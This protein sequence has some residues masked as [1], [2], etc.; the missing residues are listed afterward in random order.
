MVNMTK[1]VRWYNA[2]WESIYRIKP[3]L[4]GGCRGVELLAQ[5]EQSGFKRSKREYVSQWTFPSEIIV[6]VA[7]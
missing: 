5:I 7:P 2:I 6:G 3:A 1:G 4:L